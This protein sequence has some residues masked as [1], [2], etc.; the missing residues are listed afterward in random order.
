VD[1][2]GKYAVWQEYGGAEEGGWWYDT[3]MPEWKYGIP[4]PRFMQELGYKLCRYLNGKERERRKK[5]EDYEYTSV[6]SYKSNHYSYT[7]SDTFK[8][9][10]F[11]QERPHYE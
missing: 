8:L 7:F 4:F 5:E 3:G 10:P 9:Q 11:P 2:I 6:L 1:Y